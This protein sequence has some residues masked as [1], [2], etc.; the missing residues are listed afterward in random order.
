MFVSDRL[1]RLARDKH[2]SLFGTLIRGLNGTVS[3]IIQASNGQYQYGDW[4]DG[5]S[6][7]VEIFDAC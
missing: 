3:D 4:Q 2:S 6:I 1:E 7:F 5:T